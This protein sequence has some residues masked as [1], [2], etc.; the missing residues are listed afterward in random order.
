MKTIWSYKEARLHLIK[1]S[2]CK[3][4]KAFCTSVSV[5]IGSAL[6][7]SVAVSGSDAAGKHVHL[8]V[9]KAFVCFPLVT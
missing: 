1:T 9:L 7:A 5:G 2:P 3:K 4:S 6:A 8:E